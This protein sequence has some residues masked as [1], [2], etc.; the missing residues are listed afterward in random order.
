M[1]SKKFKSDIMQ[2]VIHVIENNAFVHNNE[3]KWNNKSSDIKGIFVSIHKLIANEIS[4]D[5]NSINL[6]I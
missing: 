4:G 2:L 3:L 1:I 6:T 5:S